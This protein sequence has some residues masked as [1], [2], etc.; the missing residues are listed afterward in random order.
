R[1]DVGGRA[2]AVASAGTRPRRA[3]SSEKGGELVESIDAVRPSGDMAEAVAGVDEGHVVVVG[4]GAV[5][6][7]VADEEGRA[8]VMA[9]DHG[10]QVGGFG[11][12]GVAP[13]LEID[14][15][16]GE[17]APLEERLD[18]AALAVADDEE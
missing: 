3:N 15:R 12:P 2:L 7:R 14:E 11:V 6:F 10:G 13:A 1:G 8:Q 4:R 16:G 9:G 5:A 18:V 17:L